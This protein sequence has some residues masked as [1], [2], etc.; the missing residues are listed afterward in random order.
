MEQIYW[1][2]PTFKK[3]F[4]LFDSFFK[5]FS[6]LKGRPFVNIKS[7]FLLRLTIS[8][9]S[10]L[11]IQYFLSEACKLQIRAIWNE[12]HTGGGINET[13]K[14]QEDVE[15]YSSIFHHKA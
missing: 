11:E 1:H 14:N 10:S 15:F 8:S 9:C 13:L 7:D 4:F 12:I 2:V 5:I 3:L 6:D